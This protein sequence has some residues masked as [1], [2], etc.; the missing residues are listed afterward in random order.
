MIASYSV[1]KLHLASLT[2]AL[3]AL[4]VGSL[5]VQAQVAPAPT[6]TTAAPAKPASRELINTLTLVGAV[7]ACELAINSKVPVQTAVISGAN[8]VAFA[9]SSVYNSQIEG[10]SASLKPEQIANGTV[11]EMIGRVKQG[12]YAKLNDTDKK[13]IDGVITEVQAQLKKQGGGK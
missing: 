6:A 12:C 13:Y 8:S 10:I 1:R 5:P 11:I 4:G 9:I 2:T 7:N 3:L